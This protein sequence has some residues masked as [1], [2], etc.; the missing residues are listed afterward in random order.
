MGSMTSLVFGYVSF[1]F[2]IKSDLFCFIQW[3]SSVLG[4]HF[5]IWVRL[6]GQC[7]GTATLPVW[8]WRCGQELSS[9]KSAACADPFW[10]GAQPHL[11]VSEQQRGWFL[12]VEKLESHLLIPAPMASSQQQRTGE[13]T[14]SSLVYVCAHTTAVRCTS[15]GR[16]G[17]CVFI[18]LQSTRSRMFDRRVSQCPAEQCSGPVNITQD[19]RILA[20]GRSWDHLV[21][22]RS[23][24][25]GWPGLY[26]VEFWVPLRMETLQ[27]LWATYFS[28]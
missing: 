13:V 14:L 28:V 23:A 6:P 5:N 11:T 26:Q 17:S 1:L 22:P 8:A 18:L 15:L 25:A 21:Q 27:H 10:E 24:R 3:D 19:H 12:P 7:W 2:C 16:E 20:A 4:L 9:L